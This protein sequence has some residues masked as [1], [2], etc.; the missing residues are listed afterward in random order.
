MFDKKCFAL[1]LE[2]M[3][4]KGEPLLNPRRLRRHDSA[5]WAL[6]SE[7]GNM[8]REY[9]RN[10]T[11]NYELAGLPGGDDDKVSSRSRYRASMLGRHIG[12]RAR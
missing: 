9:A 1:F 5:H 3:V 10:Q 8:Q 12:T 11:N 6:L 4:P 7:V 2:H